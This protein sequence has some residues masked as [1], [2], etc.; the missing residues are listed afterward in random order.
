MEEF[1]SFNHYLGLNDYVKEGDCPDKQ[2]AIPIG[3]SYR[4]SH[5]KSGLTTVSAI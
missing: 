3:S 1:T 2:G 5:D 4:N